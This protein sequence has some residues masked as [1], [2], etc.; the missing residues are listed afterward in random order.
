MTVRLMGTSNSESEYA[1]ARSCAHTHSL[2]HSCGAHAALHAKHISA[3]SIS[4]DIIL[5]GDFQR[6]HEK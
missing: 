2:T 3:P 1:G 6:K 4:A 5:E